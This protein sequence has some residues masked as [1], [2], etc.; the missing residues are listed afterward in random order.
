MTTFLIIITGILLFSLISRVVGPVLLNIAGLPGSLIGFKSKNKTDLK[1][2]IGAIVS[3][4]GQSYLYISFMIYM[5]EFSKTLIAVKNPNKYFMWIFC[6]IFL[7]GTIQQI[8]HKAN[9]EALR[10]KSDFKNPQLT[11]LLVTE[12]TSFISFFVIVF[13]PPIIDPFWIWV[14]ALPFP[15]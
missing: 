13:Y 4:I 2:V 1:Y 14:K 3:S 15:I 7:V 11:G 9:L 12:I 8:R 5:I 6:F 10:N